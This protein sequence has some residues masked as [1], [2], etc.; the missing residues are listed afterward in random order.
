MD[1]RLGFAKR[2]ITPPAGLELSGYGYYLDRKAKAVRDDLWCRAVVLEQGGEPVVLISCDLLG[3]SID[4]TRQLRE[5][6]S[7]KSGFAV[8]RILIACVHTHYGP[9]T[10][11]LEGLGEIDS[12]YLSDL[13]ES[14]VQVAEEA[15]RDL[16]P[17]TVNHASCPAGPISYNRRNNG[18]SPLDPNVQVLFFDRGKD[19]VCLAVFGCHPVSLGRSDDISG[20]W[21]AALARRLETEGYRAI[22]FQGCS[23]DVNP[24]VRKDDDQD[25]DG[26]FDIFVGTLAAGI[27][28]SKARA[29]LL[30]EPRISAREAVISIPLDLPETIEGIETIEAD[31]KRFYRNKQ[32]GFD[33]I[34]NAEAFLE[35]WAVR[36]REHYPKLRQ[37]P[38][39]DS[40]PIQAV[41]IGAVKIL[42]LPGEVFSEIGLNLQAGYAP[43]MV[44]GLCGGNI[45]YIP[46]R[47]AYEEPFDYACYAAPQFY[48]VF[49]FK[50]EIEEAIYR[51]SI[52]LLKGLDSRASGAIEGSGS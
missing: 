46:T 9:A 30:R 16:E 27:L 45:G 21:P 4:L 14:I 7:R 51:A 15:R 48:Q 5:W 12:G 17:A 43:L 1:F 50:A 10:M 52:D 34:P 26:A 41:R 38:H 42:G 40:V 47:K 44:L 33:R 6:I 22:V 25:I 36:A 37:R 29:S 49:P 23:G 20:D 11:R 24:V 32:G 28:N 31:W 3:L 8:E 19:R 39:L 2:K 35:K 18:F 13:R